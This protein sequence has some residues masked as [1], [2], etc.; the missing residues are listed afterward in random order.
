MPLDYSITFYFKNQ[1]IGKSLC[2]FNT[3]MMNKS[4]IFRATLENYEKELTNLHIT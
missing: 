2:I 3:F 1:W 4:K